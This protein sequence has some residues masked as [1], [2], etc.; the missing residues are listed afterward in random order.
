MMNVCWPGRWAAAR[1]Y[2]MSAPSGL[3]CPQSE[4]SWCGN[5]LIATKAAGLSTV[6]ANS[7]ISG[8]PKLNKVR[9]WSELA[10]QLSEAAQHT[11]PLH[12]FITQK[13]GS[14]TASTG[15]LR[16]HP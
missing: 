16:R 4:S 11:P 13:G 10:D 8:S 3:A 12:H 2:R 9:L 7:E 1:R 5:I 15:H 6:S 14:A